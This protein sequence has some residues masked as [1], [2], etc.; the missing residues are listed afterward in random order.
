MARLKRAGKREQKLLRDHQQLTAWVKM[1][2]DPDP[3]VRAKGRDGIFRRW[4]EQMGFVY[5]PD[6]LSRP[7]GFPARG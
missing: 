4:A 7:L 2:G 5:D 3:K 6:R 1:L